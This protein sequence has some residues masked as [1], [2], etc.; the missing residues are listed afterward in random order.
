MGD[1]WILK[2]LLYNV[3]DLFHHA[4]AA[5]K[6]PRW[7]NVYTTK[8]TLYI[9]YAEIAEPFY[10][11]YDEPNGQSRIDYYGG[12]VKTYQL[13]H[14]GQ[15]GASLK[16]APVTTDDKPN[17]QTCL[18]VNGT[19][20]YSIRPQTILP[21]VH[22]FVL[23][24]GF[25]CYI[26]FF[27]NSWLINI[28]MYYQEPRTCWVSRAISLPWRKWSA[29][30]GTLTHF[31]FATRSLRNIRPPECPFRCAT[32]CTDITRCWALTTITTIWTTI[33][34]ATRKFHPKCLRLNPV[35]ISIFIYLFN[36][37]KF[38]IHGL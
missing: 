30:R 31:G 28:L 2:Q 38:R 35:R 21:D 18:Q 12:M 17:Q 36:L 8:G 20:E 13:N 19:A 23:A 1:I 22:E 24:G 37:I 27:R 26:W 11:W 15:Y 6:P 33:T 34:I 25:Y 4:A 3:Y 10:A 29:R 9:P 14:V 5:T 7:D 32:K 16:V